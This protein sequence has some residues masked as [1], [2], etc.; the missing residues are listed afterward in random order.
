MGAALLQVGS[1]EYSWAT[2]ERSGCESVW[3][4]VR[5]LSWIQFRLREPRSDAVFFF[6]HSFPASM[7]MKLINAFL[8]ID[9]LLVA[10][11]PYR[12]IEDNSVSLVKSPCH[13]WPRILFA[14]PVHIAQS[15]RTFS[16]TNALV[17]SNRKTSRY[18]T[19]YEPTK[20][21]ADLRATI[22]LRPCDGC[23]L[24]DLDIWF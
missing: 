20:S 18:F 6:L 19:G 14:I 13:A 9:Y 17:L 10:P 3:G 22:L 16:S 2:P 15:I 12:D 11:T 4:M 5:G 21:W 23:V 8:N 1:M 7:Y 24:L